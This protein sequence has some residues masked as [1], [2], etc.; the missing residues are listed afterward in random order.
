M[1]QPGNELKFLSEKVSNPQD[2]WT[3][4]P[5]PQKKKNNR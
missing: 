3:P 4:M 2:N 5:P 1:S